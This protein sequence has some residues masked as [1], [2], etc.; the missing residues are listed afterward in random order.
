MHTMSVLLLVLG[1][2][3]WR[4]AGVGVH[5][6]AIQSDP[7]C[8][9][10]AFCKRGCFPRS[11]S[12]A[13]FQAQRS[14]RDLDH[15]RRQSQ[16]RPPLPL[17]VYRFTPDSVRHLADTNTG[18]ASGDLGFFL[19]RRALSTRCAID[20]TNKRCFLAPSERILWV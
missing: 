18:D 2:G 16:S 15:H 17:T 1:H 8:G 20:P 4:A 13:A 6:S 14:H 9:C 3:G 7:A 5:R 12:R 10:A 11:A 19:D